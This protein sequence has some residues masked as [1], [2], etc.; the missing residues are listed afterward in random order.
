M[1]LPFDSTTLALLIALALVA[2]LV[3]GFAGFGAGMVYVPAASALVGPKIAVIILWAIDT[4]PAMQIIFP[5][6]KKVEWKSLWP[7]LA[8]HAV[9]IWLGAWWLAHGDP[10]TLRWAISGLILVAVA[11]LWSGCKYS[12]ERPTSLSLAVGALSGLFGGAA[13]LSG[14]PVLIYWLA[15][16]EPAWLIRANI[17]VFFFLTT[18]MSGVVFFLQGMFI[19]QA[20]L[21]ALLCVPTYSI[22][23]YFGQRLFKVTSDA[24]FRR[25]AFTLILFVAI[26]TLPLFD[27]LLR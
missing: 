23:L 5:A 17:I 16:T 18:I 21:T 7:V 15:G 9:T 4:L 24:T 3:R 26:I 8:G 20:L 6:L 25:F 1:T 12:G 19:R 14:P 27:G 22:G 2:G 10:E 13:Q 11:V